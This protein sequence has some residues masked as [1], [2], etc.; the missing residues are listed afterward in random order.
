[1][2]T[3]TLAV[4]K[5]RV[6]IVL[7]LAAIVA[8]HAAFTFHFVPPTLVLGSEPI[9]GLDYDLHYEQTLR[10]V[11]AYRGA[12]RYW[13][14]DPHLLAGQLSGVM[15]AHNKLIGM[16]AIAADQLGVPVHR[17]FNLFLWIAHL[18]VPLVMCAAARLFD[19]R[20]SAALLA[21][22]LGS[23][24]WF[25]DAFSHWCFYVGMIAWGSVAYLYVLPLAAFY[26]WCT[27][28]KAQWLVV[29]ALLLV[30]L[31]HL[32]AYV[33]FCLL[34][35]MTVIY[36]RARHQLLRRDHVAVW[37]VALAVVMLNAWWLAT[38]LRF[39]HYIIDSGFF[40][41]ATPAFLLYDYLGLLK[42]LDI[43]GVI[44]VRTGFRFLVFGAAIGGLWAWRQAGDERFLPLALGFFVLLFV[45]YFG[46]W[47]DLLRQVQPYRFVLPAAYL[48]VVPAAAWIVDALGSV[49]RRSPSPA[50]L[51]LLALGAF[52]ALPK[53]AR[54]VLYFMPGWVPSAEREPPLPPPN[55]NQAIEFGTVSWPRPFDFR[56][57]PIRT[58]S[59]V[60][61]DYVKNNDKGHGR[62]L[63]EWW[64]SGERLAWATNAQILGGIRE[65][66]Q[67]HS[68]ANLFRKFSLEQDVKHHELRNYLERY[69]VQWV[70]LSNPW[71]QLTKHEDLLEPV[72]SLY[73]RR[74][75][76]SRLA[77]SWFMDGS[78]GTVKAELD[79]LTIRGSRGGDLVLKYHYL[80]SLVCRPNCE[81]YRAPIAG[82]RVGF[83]GV[84]GAPGDFEIIN[85]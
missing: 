38:A 63:V 55:I 37:A 9:V 1:M 56:H 76:R 36:W 80:D 83:I 79:R 67:A 45:A 57:Q 15:D 49:Y 71:P 70:V 20:W 12:G 8:L 6:G 85:P 29:V 24:L 65:F 47:F 72:T 62:W 10:A 81:V 39:W 18:L 33:F 43:Q 7:A 23:T 42:E 25:F 82:D 60:F 31:H 69:N 51:G 48:A 32:H 5:R 19:L 54:D 13:S 2:R 27:T 58:A 64:A 28:R 73:A 59:R 53:L 44:G 61:V 21:A 16:F 78:A 4:M 11:E 77:P 74:I 3:S 84:K 68:D 50:A 75:F 46:G 34:V 52:I 26:R 14:Y 22:F 41:D 35:P 40:L 66:N 30:L 17:S